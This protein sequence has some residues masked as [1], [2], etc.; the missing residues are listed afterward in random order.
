M[1]ALA[2]LAVAPPTF[3]SPTRSVGVLVALRLTRGDIIE[4]VVVTIVLPPV[5]LWLLEVASGVLGRRVRDVVH[6]VFAG[7]LAAVLGIEVVERFP[8]HVVTPTTPLLLVVGAIG[9]VVVYALLFTWSGP[10]TSVL[11]GAGW[12]RRCRRRSSRIRVRAAARSRGKRSRRP[13]GAG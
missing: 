11:D 9:L 7:I 2:G 8:G 5:V 10:V 1:F 6:R 12:S 13:G 3:T 4:F